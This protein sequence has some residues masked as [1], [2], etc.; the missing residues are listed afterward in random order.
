MRTTFIPI[1]A[2]WDEI[3]RR[4]TIILNIYSS[5]MFFKGRLHCKYEMSTNLERVRLANAIGSS[6]YH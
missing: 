5:R 1:E 6:R 2:S 4:E 3:M